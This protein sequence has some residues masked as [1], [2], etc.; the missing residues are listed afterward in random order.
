MIDTGSFTLD[1][2][3]RVVHHLDASTPMMAVNVLYN[4]G[5]KDE[6][7]EHTG[8]AH[9]FEHLMFGGSANIAD[10]DRA[11]ELAGGWNNAWTTN[12]YTNFYDVL[13]AANAETAFWAESDRMLALAFSDKALDVQ[14]QVVVEEFKQNFL[15]RPYGDFGHLLR[16]LIYKVHPYRW[17]T[18]GLAP[19]QILG[20]TQDDVRNFFYSHYAPNNAVLAVAGNISFDRTRELAQ[21]WFG[22]IPRRDIAPRTYSP[23]PEA[24]EPR[25]L[26][27]TRDV[28]STSIALAYPMMPYGHPLYEAADILTDILSTGT[29]SRFQRE[30]VTKGTLFTEA[31]ASILGSDDPGY[32]LVTG[33]LADN[34][35]TTLMRAEE[36][37]RGQLDRIVDKGVTPDELSRAVNKFESNLVFNN[38][39]FLARAQAIAMSA[40][41]GEDINDTLP[42]YNRLTPDHISAAAREIIRPEASRTLVYRARS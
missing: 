39:G 25:W 36:A 6:N 5:A 30:L 19:E 35:G 29:S 22:D 7:P 28:P 21:K 23:E 8:M 2:G 40:M 31:D 38:V 18:I 15:N 11:I 3:L 16:A 41:H 32:L 13:P 1:N 14:R 9:L 33:R 37:L 27:V 26:E 10:Y 42:R 20:V 24:T 34:S 12:D 4:V 17:P